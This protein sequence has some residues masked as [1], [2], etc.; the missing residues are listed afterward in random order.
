M[1]I[2]INSFLNDNDIKNLNFPR[3]N[4]TTQRNDLLDFRKLKL[5]ANNKFILRKKSSKKRKDNINYSM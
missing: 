1:K 3:F 4:F 2:N 5:L